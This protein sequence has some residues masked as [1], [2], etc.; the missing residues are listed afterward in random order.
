MNSVLKL[1]FLTLAF[2]FT[3]TA[4]AVDKSEHLVLDVRTAEEYSAS[5]VRN[6]TNIDFLKSDFKDQLLKLDK[7][8][9]YKLYCRSGNRSEKALSLMKDL[10][11]KDIEN[12]GS[13][14]QAAKSLKL[15]C[16]GPKGC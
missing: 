3:L 2:G 6:S 10:G 13:L 5:H 1:F 11:F 9:K 15:P 12:L 16:D 14:E 4:V 7:S 8:K